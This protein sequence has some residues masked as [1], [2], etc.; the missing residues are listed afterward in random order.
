MLEDTGIEPV[1]E[2]H[3]PLLHR[4]DTPRLGG[5]S[6]PM[7]STPERASLDSQSIVEFPSVHNAKA[8]YASDSALAGESRALEQLFAEVL[9]RTRAAGRTANYLA[10]YAC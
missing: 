2:R 7:L 6:V 1:E 10:P 3:I 8:L 9:S 4:L 5:G